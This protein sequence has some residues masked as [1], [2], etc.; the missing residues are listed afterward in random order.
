MAALDLL[1][2]H[3]VLLRYR[4]TR[5]SD[6]GGHFLSS[7]FAIADQCSSSK[8]ERYRLLSPIIQRPDYGCAEPE[9]LPEQ[10]VGGPS[11]PVRL[12]RLLSDEPYHSIM[13]HVH[14][15]FDQPRTVYGRLQD[16]PIAQVVYHIEDQVGPVSSRRV[17]SNQQSGPI[18]GVRSGRR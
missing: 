7:D 11:L 9:R 6:I 13:F 15:R 5:K 3:D 1:F 16:L 4:F 8:F 17:L 2:G 18:L 10:F 12:G 14:F